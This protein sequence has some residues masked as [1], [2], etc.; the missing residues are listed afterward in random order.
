M[1][2]NVGGRDELR[3]TTQ[4]GQAQA[5]SVGRGDRLEPGK[6]SMGHSGPS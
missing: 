1:E 6:S 2:T 5:F 3:T 4:G